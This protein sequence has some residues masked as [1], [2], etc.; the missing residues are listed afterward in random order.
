MS[1]KE[2]LAVYKK[3]IKWFWRIFFIG[4]GVMA[5]FILLLSLGVFGKL[6]SFDEL[7][8]PQSSLATQILTS[9][10]ELLGRFYRENRTNATLKEIPP[11]LIQALVAT[12]DRR[13]YEHSGIDAKSV[14]R[15]IIKTLIL[16]QEEAGGGSTLTQQLA[17]NLYGRPV[18]SNKFSLAVIKLKEW[19]TA[20]K[21]ERRYTKEEIIVMYLNTIPYIYDASGIKTAS[22]T[23]FNKTVDSLSI[24]ES[25]ILVGMVNNP[26]LFNPVRFPERC[27]ERRNIV[28]HSMVETGDLSQEEYDVYKQKPI[29]LDFKRQDHKA[30]NG[31]YF[32]EYLRQW[33]GDWVEEN[34]KPDGGKWDIYKDG[35]KIYTTCLLYTSPSPR[36]RTRYRMPSSA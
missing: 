26:S 32:R 20:A 22:K 17:K 13:F 16:R 14:M 24:D 23:F 19:V 6:P 9:D 5:L 27:L 10:G 12:E 29:A 21:L 3:Q 34:E 35:L 11:H 28:L 18:A 4:A 15:V 25:A 1:V 30:G 8:N 31:T 2:E 33:L 7:E 36:D